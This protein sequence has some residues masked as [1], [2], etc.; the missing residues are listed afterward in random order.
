M[1][2]SYLLGCMQFTLASYDYH[3]GTLLLCRKDFKR[4]H[5]IGNFRLVR[6]QEKLEKYPTFYSEVHHK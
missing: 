2:N 3:I 5:S 4:I 1:K 6:I